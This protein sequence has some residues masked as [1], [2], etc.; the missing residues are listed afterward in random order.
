MGRYDLRPQRVHTYASQLLSHSRLTTPPP[1][2][3]PISSN[4]PPE[5]LVRPLLQRSQIP[6]TKIPKSRKASRTFRPVHLRY[7]EDRLRWDYFNDHPWELAR[8]RVVL[9]NDGR[10][11]EKWDWSVPLDHGVR[12]PRSGAVDEEGRRADLEWDR[13]RELQSARPING[14]A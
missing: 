2:L 13:V 3:A 8:P 1:W 14:E 9:E 4:P 6:T 7:E 12:R 5:R 10:D 11:A